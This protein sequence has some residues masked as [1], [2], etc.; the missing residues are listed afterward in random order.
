MRR[1]PAAVGALALAVAAAAAALGVDAVPPYGVV[2]GAALT[3][4]VLALVALLSAVSHREPPAFDPAG[5]GHR[6]PGDDVD[7]LL[8]ALSAS[9]RRDPSAERRELRE[10]LR[11]TATDV[12]ARRFDCTPAE[13]RRRLESGEWTDDRV[14]AAYFRSAPVGRAAHLRALA[15]G[16]PPARRRARRA[17]DELHRLETAEAPPDPAEVDG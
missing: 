5:A 13:A 15:T 6:A 14:A 7:A 16:E 3:A 12:L 8:A 9:G 4:A 2:V 11:A 17:I 10:R 1:L